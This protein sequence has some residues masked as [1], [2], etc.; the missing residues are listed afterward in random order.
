MILVCNRVLSVSYSNSFIH[1]LTHSL[2]LTTRNRISEE[3]NSV[4]LG[5][6]CKNILSLYINRKC[7]HFSVVRIVSYS[8][9]STVYTWN[10]HIFIYSAHLSS[11]IFALS[12]FCVSPIF[13]DL[14]FGASLWCCR[15][16]SFCIFIII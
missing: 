1:S 11:F 13:F 16:F 12:S 15:Y 7:V 14:F 3:K 8:T 6:C 10:M 9:F 5:R 4:C 2:K